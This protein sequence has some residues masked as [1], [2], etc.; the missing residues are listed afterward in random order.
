MVRVEKVCVSPVNGNRMGRIVLDR[1]PELETSSEGAASMAF[2]FATAP[3]K[4][5]PNSGRGHSKPSFPS[6]SL[7]SSLL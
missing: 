2:S 7:H 3:L 5:L 1:Y 4:A 6:T